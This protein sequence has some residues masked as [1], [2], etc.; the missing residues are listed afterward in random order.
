M[1]AFL[2]G[3][4]LLVAGPVL[5]ADNRVADIEQVSKVVEQTLNP[6]LAKII[7][8]SEYDGFYKIRGTMRRDGYKFTRVRNKESFPDDRYEALALDVSNRVEFDSDAR[9]IDGRRK[10]GA[11][12]YVIMFKGGLEGVRHQGEGESLALVMIDQEDATRPTMAPTT[13]DE[14]LFLLDVSM[15]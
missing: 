9:T 4:F 13:P 8:E 7:L 15:N 12:A 1:R 2:T 14:A 11:T 6:Q 3:I 5:A 10:P